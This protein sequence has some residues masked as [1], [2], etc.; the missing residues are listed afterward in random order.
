[1]LYV[2]LLPIK[3]DRIRNVA[4]IHSTSLTNVKNVLKLPPCWHNWVSLTDREVDDIMLTFGVPTI[5]FLEKEA[6]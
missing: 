2:V 1:M 4:I 5:K 3:K 6:Y